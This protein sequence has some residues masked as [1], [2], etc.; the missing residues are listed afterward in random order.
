M[1]LRLTDDFDTVMVPFNI[2]VA[3][4]RDGYYESDIGVFPIQ[5]VI[6]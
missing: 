6:S 5:I 4:F 2:L 1:A 3:L